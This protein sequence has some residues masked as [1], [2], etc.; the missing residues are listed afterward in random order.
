MSKRRLTGK[1]AVWFGLLGTPVL[2][3]AAITLV[4]VTAGSAGP[5][6]GARPRGERASRP[7]VTS[8]VTALGSGQQTL[9]ELQAYWTPE[10]MANAKPYPMDDE[11]RAVVRGRLGAERSPRARPP[12]RGC[13]SGRTAASR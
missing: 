13:G 6:K 9:A 10:R 8:H 7:L 5:S 1:R 4:G 11:Q 12:S 2:L 3:V